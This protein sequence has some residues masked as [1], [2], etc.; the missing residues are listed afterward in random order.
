MAG[1]SGTPHA[2]LLF[3]FLLLHA[4]FS[5]LYVAAVLTDILSTLPAE[6]EL[7]CLFVHCPSY[8]FIDVVH[9]FVLC[10][11]P[12]AVPVFGSAITKIWLT[13]CFSLLSLFLSS[14]D[15]G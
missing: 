1:S 2:F 3:F 14:S 4:A 12:S 10:D 6:Q 7:L 8:V 11:N 9:T 13:L 5:V 15:I